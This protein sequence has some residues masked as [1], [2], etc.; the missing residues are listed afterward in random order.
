MTIK[1]SCVSRSAVHVCTKQQHNN[2]HT[3]PIAQ[4]TC[5]TST[6]S[7][8]SHV[9]ALKPARLADHFQLL[10]DFLSDT[11]PQ[12]TG[13]GSHSDL[14]SCCHIFPLSCTCV[15]VVVTQI[16]N[17]HKSGNFQRMA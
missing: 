5:A 8:F 1:L 14:S 16:A 13:G 7:C 2:T 4:G 3:G 17:K 9:F 12:Q 6:T 10:I 15:A 11:S